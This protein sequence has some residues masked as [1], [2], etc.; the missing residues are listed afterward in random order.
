MPNGHDKLELPEDAV[1][2]SPLSVAIQHRDKATMDMVSSALREKRVKLAY[3][4]VVQTS[5]TDKMAFYEGLLRVLDPTG[6]VIP[7]RDF[8]DAVET[9]EMG[10]QLDTLALEQGVQVLAAEPSL[11]LSI[12][13]SARSIGYPAWQTVLKRGL[14]DNPTIGER[15]ILEITERTAIIMPELVQVFMK[16]MQREGISFALDDFG[17]GYTS[18]RHL[19]DF[20][21]DIMKIDGE[22]INGIHNDPDNQILTEAM[23]AVARKFDMFTVAECVENYEDAIYLAKLGVDCMQG[24]YFGAPTLK[25]YWLK[26]A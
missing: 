9:T 13:M 10:R 24:Y 25:P 14:K 8:V 23:I 11:R 3:Q 17:A 7:A 22:Y 1:S 20:Y 2:G 6:R 18:F 15:L 12:N 16:E 26:A 21:F 4:P 19:K 5:Q